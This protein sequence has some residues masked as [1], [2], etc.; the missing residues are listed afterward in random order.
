MASSESIVYDITGKQ[1]LG[2]SPSVAGVV[3]VPKGVTMIRQ[4]PTLMSVA[5]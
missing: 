4:R 2:V 5:K 3:E 1:V